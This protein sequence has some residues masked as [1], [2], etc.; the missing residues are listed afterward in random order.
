MNPD[1]KP[2]IHLFCGP[3][4][5]TNSSDTTSWDKESST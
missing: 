3:N 1:L 4:T 5:T 2:R